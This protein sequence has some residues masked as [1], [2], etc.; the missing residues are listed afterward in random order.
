M[1]IAAF[2]PVLLATGISALNLKLPDSATFSIVEA[3]MRIEQV[4]IPEFLAE[5]HMQELRG[6]STASSNATNTKSTTASS[7]ITLHGFCQVPARNLPVDDIADIVSQIGSFCGDKFA[8]TKG[9]KI[10]PYTALSVNAN[11]LRVSV[12]SYGSE[13]QCDVN[14]IYE[15]WNFLAFDCPVPDPPEYP[16]PAGSFFQ[17]GWDKTFQ[18]QSCRDA[19]LCGMSYSC[20]DV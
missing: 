3:G 16:H 19:T 18:Q 2:V 11:G 17:G 14:E 4:K 12:C 20:T 15:G 13:S 9:V 5:K 10:P 7:P 1:K 8:G 6:S